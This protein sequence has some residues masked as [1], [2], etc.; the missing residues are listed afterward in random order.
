MMESEEILEKG[1][2]VWV[3]CPNC[4]GSGFHGYDNYQIECFLCDGKKEILAQ[5]SRDQPISVEVDVDELLEVLEPRR[6]P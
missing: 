6:L 1:E 4:D 5:T 3:R 2:E